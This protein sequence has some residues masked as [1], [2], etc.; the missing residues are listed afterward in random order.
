[1]NKYIIKPEKMGGTTYY[2]I[3]K[4]CLWWYV[5][6][7]RWNTGETAMSRL[8]ELSPLKLKSKGY[9]HVVKPVRYETE[10]TVVEGKAEIFVC[11]GE[12]PIS[13]PKSL[14]TRFLLWF[15]I[16]KKIRGRCL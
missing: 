12:L 3:Y 14:F 9:S 13:K 6:F 16:K 1:M 15:G 8:N 7:E 11:T 5:F 10:W 4:K 2:M